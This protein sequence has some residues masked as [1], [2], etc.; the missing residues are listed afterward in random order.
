MKAVLLHAYG[1]V[2]QLSYE[3]VTDPVPNPGEVLVKT[4]A[5]SLNPIDWKIRRGEVKERMPVQLPEILGRDLVGEVVGIGEG[6]T[7]LT[8][9][10]L[11]FG[12]VN[13]TYAELV[14][15]K[16]SD[17]AVLPEGLDPII[18]AALPLVLLTGTQLIESG[19]L[20]KAGETVLVTGALGGVGRT[21]VHV[22]KLHKAVV[23]AGVRTSQ[24]AEA[25]SL[26]A[27]SVA[28]LDN[29]A[30][31]ASL[32]ELDAVADTVGHDV[33]DKLIPKIKTNGV[34]ATVLGKPASA[35]A[36]IR[37]A[38]VYARPDPARLLALVADI[39]DG[40]FT[41]PIGMKFKL[42]DI[43]K[44]QQ[45]AEKGGIGKVIVTP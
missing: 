36:S 42:A 28:E 29:E 16:A 13:H 19:V 40:K 37:V 35:G 10:Q 8:V 11:V 3:D 34:L 12:L 33:I 24:V 4:I 1:G 7:T 21:A 41:I 15:C 43:R 5:I 22:A 39:Q 17:L 25:K 2:E 23:I 6:V 18:A 32:H 45:M 31:I 26:G 9:G 30:S 20:P 14:A 44:A 27:D 38:E